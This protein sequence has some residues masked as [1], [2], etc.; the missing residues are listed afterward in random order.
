[1]EEEGFGEIFKDKESSEFNFEGKSGI[2]RMAGNRVNN[3]N[4]IIQVSLP[5]SETF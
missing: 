4:E 1:M 5:T 3:T 2:G